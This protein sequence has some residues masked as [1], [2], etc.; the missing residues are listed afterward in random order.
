MKKSKII[1][2]VK[3]KKDKSNQLDIKFNIDGNLTC[4][5]TLQVFNYVAQQINIMAMNKKVEV[6]K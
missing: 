3:E 2:N 1:I 5:E 4:G 6:E